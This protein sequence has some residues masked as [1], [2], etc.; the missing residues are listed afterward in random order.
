M[1]AKAL[2]DVLNFA[3]NH[4]SDPLIGIKC[5][6]KYPI[7]QYSRVAEF[8]K[9]CNNIEHAAELYTKYCSLF[10]TVG[11]PSGV[12]LE[13]GIDRIIWTTNFMPS[14]I[15]KYALLNELIV[16]NLMTSLN[17]LAWNTPNAVRI[18]NIQHAA[19]LPL[20]HY[21]DLLDCE[22]RFN[23]EEYSII[24]NDSVKDAPF[25]M[26]NQEELSKVCLR[27]DLA[28]K[29]LSKKKSL[30]DRIEIQI[31]RSIGHGPHDKT[32]IAKALGLPE[33]TM[34]RDLQKNGTSFKHVKNRILQ[35]VA[36]SMIDQ[37]LP[38]VEI[39]LAL[40]Y[41]DQPAF[42]RAY[43]N[44]FGSTPKKHKISRQ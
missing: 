34:A 3:A 31:R 6:L 19:R 21:E 5:S 43:K 29:E 26:S 11:A 8:L 35:E 23:Q 4:L 2:A 41:N 28:L 17:W 39:A 16:T 36:I 40:G 10:H 27:F 37:G 9:L 25:A 20:N 15:E 30:V 13:G 38:L 18:I 1:D 22:I 32:S 14:L 33:R 42:T 24:L 7:L 44:W 12:I